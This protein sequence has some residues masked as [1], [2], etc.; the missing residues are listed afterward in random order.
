MAAYVVSAGTVQASI[1][2]GVPTEGDVVKCLLTY[3]NNNVSFYVN[4]V[5]VGTDITCQIPIVLNKLSVGYSHDG[6]LQLNSEIG[7][8][9]YFKK[10]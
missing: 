8:V 5:A 3:Q 4:G 7:N 2:F 10:S 6:T 1:S 9:M